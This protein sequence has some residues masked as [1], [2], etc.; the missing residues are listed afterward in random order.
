MRTINDRSL[1]NSGRLY[2]YGSHDT[3][4]YKQGIRLWVIPA[5]RNP[6][7]ARAEY[8]RKGGRR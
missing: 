8:G 5:W 3:I 7:A 4:I 1:S 6:Q 2:V